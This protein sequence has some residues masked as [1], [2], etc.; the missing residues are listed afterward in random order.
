M[1]SSQNIENQSLTEPEQYLSETKKIE[2]RN[3]YF[4]F[5]FS[6]IFIL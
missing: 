1:S 3:F 4:Y 2:I 6:I 5:E